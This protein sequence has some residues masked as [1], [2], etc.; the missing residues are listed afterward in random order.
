MKMPDDSAIGG[1]EKDTAHIPCR[2]EV[3]VTISSHGVHMRV[4]I[5]TL[6]TLTGP[7]DS[8]K[9]NHAIAEG[10]LPAMLGDTPPEENLVGL[11]INLINDAVANPP[12]LGSPYRAQIG[13]GDVD[14]WDQDGAVLGQSDLVGVDTRVELLLL[15][16][17]LLI[18]ARDEIV[19]L[20]VQRDAVDFV[21]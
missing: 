10:N 15:L 17:L 16:L 4:L 5:R 19:L 14:S 7:V 13:I 8:L 11:D 12:I 18:V 1:K 9:R 20:T 2:N 6:H 21:V 3:V